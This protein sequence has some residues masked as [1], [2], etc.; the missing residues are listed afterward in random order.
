M[1]VPVENFLPLGAAAPHTRIAGWPETP[2]TT[3]GPLGAEMALSEEEQAI[4]NV[5]HRFAEHEMRPLGRQLDRLRPE[6]VIAADSPLWPF[7]ARYHELGFSTD[8]LFNMPPLQRARIQCLVNEELCW[9]DVGLAFTVG[10]ATFPR[11]MARSFGNDYLAER[12]PETTIGCWG[13]TEPDHGSDNLDPEGEARHAR[14]EYGRPNCIATLKTDR[15]VVN[16]QKSAWVSNGTIAQLCVLFC[17]CDSGAGPDT[18]HG[19]VVIVP[20]DARGV[21]KGKPLDKMGQRTLNQGEIFFDNVEVP[22]ENL[23]AGPEFYQRAVYTI[24]QEANGLMAVGL[25]GVGR[26]A[27]E[28]AFEYAHQRRQGGMPLIKHQHIAYRLF[29]MYRKLEASRALARR[30]VEYN[31]TAALP[32]LSAA[33]AAK[34]HCTQAAYEIAHEALQMFGGNGMTCEYPLEKLLRDTRAGL[35]EDGCNELL[36]IK[37]GFGLARPDLL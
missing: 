36:S 23:L 12:W 35:I 1:A 33:M 8:A 24:H 32:S 18:K 16:G 19:C 2:H 20:L 10:A 3:L 13:I 4:W 27:Y 30:V 7:I 11:F 29:Q 21:S 37:G 15:I 14:G 22:R 17:A 5:V 9:G 6:Q 34:V 28:L 25:T 26:A 31:A